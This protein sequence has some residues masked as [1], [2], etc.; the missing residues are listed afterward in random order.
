MSSKTIWA[1][2]IVIIVLGGGYWYISSSKSG[3][4]MQGE[5]TTGGVATSTTSGAEMSSQDPM[6]VGTWQSTDDANFTRAFTAD[7]H[8]TDAYK[9]DSAATE[10]GTFV[11]VDPMKEDVGVPTSTV[12]GMTVLKLN[13]ASGP[14]YFGVQSETENSL[15]LIYL[16]RGNILSFTKV[17]AH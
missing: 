15:K 11:V 8:F 9:G 7:G 17:S 6:M 1:I 2:I 4:M 3:E 12:V 16:G 14:L 10:T 13:F 5:K